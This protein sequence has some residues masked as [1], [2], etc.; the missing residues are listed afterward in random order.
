[1]APLIKDSVEVANSTAAAP[2]A[3]SSVAP[4]AAAASGGTLRADALSL[5]VP[6][7][8]HGSRLSEAARG[9]APHTEPFEEETGTMIVFPHGG[10]LRMS[11]A[12]TASQM[13]VVTNLKTRQDAICRVVKVRTFSNMQGYVE[14]EFTHQQPG[15]WGVHFPSEGPAQP[16]APAPAIPVAPP[17]VIPEAAAP[18]APVQAAPTPFVAPPP[19]VMPPA[20][21]PPAVMT[22]VL[23]PVAPIA[24][25]AF[26]PPAPVIPAAPSKPETTFTSFGTQEKVQ[27]FASSTLVPAAERVAQSS[28][29]TPALTRPE[30]VLPTFDPE[31]LESSP[32]H[33]ARS[34]AS[35]DLLAAPQATP[36]PPSLTMTE[37]R[38]DQRGIAVAPPAD[39]PHAVAGAEHATADAHDAPAQ[40]SRAVFGSFSGGAALSGSHSVPVDAFGARLDSSHEAATDQPGAPRTS[41][42]ML[43]ATVVGGI[44][45]F[46]PHTAASARNGAANSNTSA[47]PQALAF[48]T[49]ASVPDAS[50]A[51]VTPARNSATH[52]VPIVAQ[53]PALT[54]SIVVN[55]NDSSGEGPRIV[56]KPA[57][58]LAPGTIT[59]AVADHPVSSQRS[60]ADQSVQAPSLDA[61]SSENSA[62]SGAL[63]GIVSSS[64]AAPVAP[65]VRQEGP[66]KVGGNVKEP[67]LISR[68]MPEYPV[69]AKQANIQGDVVVKTTIDQKGNVVDMK[70][71]SGPAMLRGPALA[72]LRRW[73]YEPSTLDGQ[74]IA[75]QMLVTIKFSANR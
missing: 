27:L 42:W 74:P 32:A 58:N 28:S 54:P 7:K 65:E 16:S 35:I 14:V 18:P 8:V 55:G 69:V 19:A 50:A 53:A 49:P 37:L 64:V 70:I 2:T 68:V 43:I 10:V 3:Q 56:P 59:D 22:P 40:S 67:R 71:V 61:A 11:T 29:A 21:A 15:Y 23:P 66:I 48:Q 41:S 6:V 72:A 24:P 45:Y 46:R 47:V 13:L 44:L 63:S 52:P 31:T 62:D 38:G 36:A 17:V 34:V 30:S 25:A 60:E 39:A 33:D 5:E 9:A 75:V 12:V 57:S 4:K 51:E 1:M 20:P 26:H 73:R